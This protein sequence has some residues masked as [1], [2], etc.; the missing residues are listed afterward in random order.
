MN[1]KYKIQYLCIYYGKTINIAIHF[2][3]KN[4]INYLLTTPQN[5]LNLI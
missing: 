2:P 1:S 5:K 4:E 3:F